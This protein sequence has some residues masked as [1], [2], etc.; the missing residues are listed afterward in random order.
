MV[1]AHHYDAAEVD[2]PT[3]NMPRRRHAGR[4]QGRL[5]FEQREPYGFPNVQLGGNGGKEEQ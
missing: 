5:R 3:R 2:Y 1:R 4:D